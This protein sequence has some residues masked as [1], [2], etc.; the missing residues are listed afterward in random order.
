M[1]IKLTKKTNLE[2]IIQRKISLIINSNFFSASSVYLFM[3]FLFF[4]VTCTQTRN[5]ILKKKTN[6]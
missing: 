1:A 2:Q 5:F 6:K 3:E 4:Q